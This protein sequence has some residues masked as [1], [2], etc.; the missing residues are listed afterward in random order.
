MGILKIVW[1][2]KTD[3]ENLTFLNESNN[4]RVTFGTCVL[5]SKDHLNK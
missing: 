1:T 5:I 4:V 3:H 2:Y